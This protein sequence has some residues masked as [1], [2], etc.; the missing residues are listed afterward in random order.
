MLYENDLIASMYGSMTNHHPFPPSAFFCNRAILAARNNDIHYLNS[1]I[2]S[3]LHGEHHEYCSADS[4]SIEFPTQQE[5]PNIPVEF[6][7]SLNMS[8]LP[9]AHLSLK[10]GCP[11]I[12]LRNIDS[13]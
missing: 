10:L 7:H 3:R 5:N 8:G 4:F 11:I 6:L 13:K 12:L 1:T 9:I 2:L